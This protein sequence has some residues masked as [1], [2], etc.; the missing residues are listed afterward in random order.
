M[1]HFSHTAAW[2]YRS[3]F[4]LSEQARRDTLTLLNLWE[5]EFVVGGSIVLSFT[6]VASLGEENYISLQRG[7][8]RRRR[9]L[10]R[11]DLVVM[12]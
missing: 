2:V 7:N 6:S 5:E 4:S 10:R 8:W 1:T 11:G 3:L 9:C 12:F